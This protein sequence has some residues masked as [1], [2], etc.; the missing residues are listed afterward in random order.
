MVDDDRQR[1]DLTKTILVTQG[2]EVVVFHDASRGIEE[3]KR[4]IPDLIL[5]DIM[6]PEIS[7]GQAVRKLR[8]IPEL[9]DILALF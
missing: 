1:A 3:A 7:G 5:M 9:K 8:E 2:Y 4:H 6:L